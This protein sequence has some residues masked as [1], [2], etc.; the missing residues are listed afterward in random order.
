MTNT[1]WDPLDQYISGSAFV[2][3]SGN[4]VATA[5]TSTGAKGVRAVDGHSSGKYY[6]ELQISNARNSFMIFGCGTQQNAFAT[7]DMAGT[8]AVNGLGQVFLGTTSQSISL[9]TVNINDV[10]CF[11]IDLDNSRA[12]A[13]R[14]N[15]NWNN[16]AANNPSTNVGGV[17]ISSLTAAGHPWFPL[18]VA[19]SAA[20]EV[21]TANFGDSAFAQS[22]PSGFTSG[23]PA[24]TTT[25]GDTFDPLHTDTGLLLS[26]SNRTFSANTP[27]ANSNTRSTVSKTSGK[28]YFEIYCNFSGTSIGAGVGNSSITTTF[29]SP[30][31]G[32]I[33]GA[34]LRRAGSIISWP[35][36]G[37]NFNGTSGNAPSVGHTIQVAVDLDN[38][39]IWTRIFGRTPNWNNN[40]SADPGTGTGGLSLSGLGALYVAC[41]MPSGEST[42]TT[43]SWN[44]TTQQKLTPPS[45]FTAGFTATT[46]CVWDAANKSANISL[47]RAATCAASWVSVS[48]WKAVRATTSHS[49]GK[50]YL[51]VIQG[52]VG[53]NGMVTGFGNAS[54]NTANYVG[55][56]A[57][58]FGYQSNNGGT[59]GISGGWQSATKMGTVIQIAIDLDAKLV[60]A[61][62]DG[63]SNWNNSGTADP[64]TGVGGKS[65]TTIGALFPA[66][67]LFGA[68]N[69]ATNWAVLNAGGFSFTGT[70][71]SGFSAWATGTPTGT[72]IGGTFGPTTWNAATKNANITLTGPQLQATQSNLN[73][74]WAT[75]FS[76]SNYD[77]GRVYFE[78]T[79]TA[80]DSSSGI[81]FG[82]TDGSA[83][84]ANGVYVGSTTLA[85]G[86]QVTTGS[87]YWAA[88]SGNTGTTWSSA[89]TSQVVGCAVDFNI[90]LMWV[91]NV[92]AN[93]PW[94]ADSLANPATGTHGLS[95]PPGD[96]YIGFSG[97]SNG[98][99][100]SV[101]LN[102]GAEPFSS[103]LPSGFSAWDSTGAA[104]ATA[105]FDA[106]IREV[107]LADAGTTAIDSVT[108]EVLLADPAATLQVDN[109]IAEALIAN[110]SSLQVAGVM[111]E[112]LRSTIIWTP[113]S[114]AKGNRTYRIR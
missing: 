53:N 60:W 42:A 20:A 36:N 111:G 86:Y 73:N 30:T 28:W 4:L 107:L 106:V 82:L 48:T 17:D 64:A 21:F 87:T 76:T 78:L 81:I 96:L 18:V 41:T 31:P 19:D 66:V 100:D 71:P 94:N 34:L 33:G 15:G 85:V 91:K 99:T 90:G 114:A 79:I 83:G 35:V 37:T 75:V 3:S 88:S 1:K 13:R 39:L 89:I 103:T 77:S 93:S 97:V 16:N 104:G 56:D 50:F 70:I 2:L 98:A 105:Q 6:F 9:G 8:F 55:S 80:L 26:N 57:N 11:A 25:A 38:G 44:S 51:E 68:N 10:V 101:V 12:W 59:L 46:T 102:T 22:V 84:T 14:N 74:T 52:Y 72:G 49:T 32:A 61:R 67:S 7:A 40:A 24:N 45:G 108:R 113:V 23:W 63:S 5:D 54:L 47:F 29:W 110:T 69:N 95:I 58:S 92:T 27:A 43:Y 65:Y 62:T 109:V 112:V